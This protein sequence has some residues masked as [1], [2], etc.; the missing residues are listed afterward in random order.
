MNKKL[1]RIVILGSLAVIVAAAAILIIIKP[2][3][4]DRQIY[5]SKFSMDYAVSIEDTDIAILDVKIKLNIIKLSKDKSIYLVKGSVD[6][7]SLVCEDENGNS[8]EYVDSGAL[9]EIGPIDDGVKTVSIKYPV[10]VG[11]DRNPYGD[12]LPCKLGCLYNDLL[13]FSGENVL[14]TPFIDILDV[15][16]AGKYIEHISFDLLTK[17]DWQA[18]MP[19]QTPLSDECSFYIDKPA[20]GVFNSISKSGFC[21]GHFQQFSTPGYTYYLDMGITDIIPDSAISVYSEFMSY[22]TDLFGSPLDTPF[23]LLRNDRADNALILGGVGASSSA[24]S[25]DLR[26]PDDCE[27]LSRTIFYAFFDSKIKAYNLKFAPNN[28]AYKGLA[29]YYVTESGAA[30]PGSVME[31]Y[32]IEIQ[33]VFEMQYLRYL[34]FSLKEIGFLTLGPLAESDMGFAQN[35]FYMDTKVPVILNAVNSIIKERTGRDDGLIKSLVEYAKDEKKFDLN[36]MLSEVCGSEAESIRKYFTGAALVPNNGKNNADY[37]YSPGEIVEELDYWEEAF[38]ELFS[39]EYVHYPYVEVFLLDEKN[40]RSEAEK[41]DVHYNTEIIENEVRSFSNT[42]DRILLQYAMRCKL[43]GVDD[44]TDLDQDEIKYRLE[45]DS[46]IDKW[47][48]FCQQ[49]GFEMNSYSS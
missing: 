1:K 22:Y 13:V 33:D 24:M 12:A 44:I 43:A 19:Y 15:S 46:S 37:I 39:R 16:A 9:V 41:Q 38:A 4:Q 26:S 21:F 32:S 18:V 11:Y 47:R 28:W 27:T 48:D 25:I 20:W 2:F 42:L 8:I 5:Q 14:M 36:K 49:V 7:P 17:Y 35:L 30:L 40:F 23:I 10:R 31:E 45:D 3:K 34:Y 29:D 6:T